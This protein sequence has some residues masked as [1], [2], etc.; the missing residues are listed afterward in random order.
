M[1]NNPSR[2]SWLLNNVPTN[3]HTI[4]RL[5]F[6]ESI[7]SIALLYDGFGY[8]GIGHYFRV[9]NYR[10]LSGSIYTLFL[11]LAGCR[12]EKSFR[13]NVSLLPVV[14]PT[15]I[16]MGDFFTKMLCLGLYLAKKYSNRCPGHKNES[17][18]E[19]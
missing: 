2:G 16:R 1:T 6:G 18:T 4:I 3:G 9:L 13:E 19:H 11:A 7:V 10:F 14:G 15:T 17:K 12:R 8:S 5:N